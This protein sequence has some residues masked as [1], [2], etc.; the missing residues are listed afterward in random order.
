MKSPA[1]VFVKF[2]VPVDCAPCAL[3]RIVLQVRQ[4]ALHV[5]TP[6]VS[7]DW[8]NFAGPAFKR[9]RVGARQPKCVVLDIEGTVAPI[10]FVT[11]TLFPYAK[12]HL[13]SFLASTF[14]DPE[15]QQAVSGLR[16]Q[17]AL[18][19]PILHITRTWLSVVTAAGVLAAACPT[20]CCWACNGTVWRY[21][22]RC[23]LLLHKAI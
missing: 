21:T 5:P 10:T 3:R 8:Y 15:T 11:E 18:V 22:V 4:H 17:A 2:P 7:H 16:E 14:E 6:L 1:P 12:S 19:W 9:A 13:R 20:D 23:V